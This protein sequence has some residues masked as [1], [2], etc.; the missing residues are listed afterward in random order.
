MDL[1]EQK[2]CKAVPMP[3]EWTKNLLEKSYFFLGVLRMET[4]ALQIEIPLPFFCDE[5]R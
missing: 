1:M 5:D 4:N 3:P 2:S